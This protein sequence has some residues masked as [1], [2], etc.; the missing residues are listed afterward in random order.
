MPINILSAEHYAGRHYFCL[1][2]CISFRYPSSS[3]MPKG[4][5]KHI[6]NCIVAC[7]HADAQQRATDN[8]DCTTCAWD[9]CSTK[10]YESCPDF[11][12]HIHTHLI[13][14][15]KLSLHGNQMCKWCEEGEICAEEGNGGWLVPDWANHFTTEHYLNANATIAIDHC[16]I[17]GQWFED[18]MGDGASWVGH[19]MGHYD[20]MFSPFQEWQDR[21]IDLQP[22]SIVNIRAAISY[23]PR[24][25]VGGPLLHGHIK[26]GIALHPYFCLFC[27]FDADLPI[28]RRMMQ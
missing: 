22:T 1:S 3:T 4:I 6:H 27:V 16:T 17:C 10:V 23:D 21:L 20:D 19:C 13:L 15:T 26:R 12:A 24:D 8:F 9:G 25:S 5:G 28:M 11:I 18:D 14:L 7:M 2:L